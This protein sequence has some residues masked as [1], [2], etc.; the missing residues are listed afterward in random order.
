MDPNTQ[1]AAEGRDFSRSGFL[2]ICFNQADRGFAGVYFE[3]RV[4]N[5]T[6]LLLSLRNSPVDPAT[7]L[8]TSAPG[9]AATVFNGGH[10]SF[11][12]NSAS[13][14]PATPVSL[15]TRIDQEEYILMPNAS[16][17][18]AICSGSL[19]RNAEHDIRIIAPMTDDHGKGI[20]QLE[21]IWL[22]KGAQFERIEGTIFNDLSSDEGFLSAQSDEV[23]KKHR[24]GLSR[25]LKG[26]IH[27]RPGNVQE[28]LKE[29]DGIQDFRDRRKLLEVITD[30]P[31]S[32][33]RRKVSTRT[34]GADGLLAGVM[35]WE[36]LLGEMFGADH[37]SISV[38]GMC[39][40]QDCIGGVGRPNGI[41]DIFF[42]RSVAHLI[43]LFPWEL[44]IGSGPPGSAFVEHPWL[45]NG[46]VPDVLV[47]LGTVDLVPFC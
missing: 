15:L 26:R 10:L 45:F 31:G 19:Q 2:V 47:S 36:Y 11:R 18:V 40:V 46:N 1:P 37:I 34:G 8:A 14:K 23:G 4:K 43:L 16:A 7:S 13:N 24:A 38:D 30:A 33:G 3:I 35:G 42:R 20:V 29:D 27:D 25:L 5:T 6:S 9:S 44:T 12:P 28:V 39:L 17:L 41:G 22:D 21:G 32:S